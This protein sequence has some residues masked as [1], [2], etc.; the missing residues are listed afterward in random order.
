MAEG[1]RIRKFPQT[2]KRAGR[3]AALLLAGC[4][5]LGAAGMPVPVQAAGEGSIA[6]E[7]DVLAVNIGETKSVTV[8]YDLTGGFA[9]MAV[10]T[11]DS[12]IAVAALTDNGNGTATLSV[13]G[14]TAGSTVAAVY[15]ISNAAV[16]DYITIR[17]GLA[18]DGEVLTQTDGTSLVTTYED[19]MVY[20]NY[21]LTGR[22]GASVAIAEMGIER[23]S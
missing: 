15:R 8:T 9:D 4:I 17:S 20:Y 7:E 19:R 23:G 10:L 6:M 13:A 22:N 1:Q 3:A 18:A 11:A 14:V 5:A 16:V 2:G 21:T 12:N